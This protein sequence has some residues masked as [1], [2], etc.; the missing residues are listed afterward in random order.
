M[1]HIWYIL[2]KKVEFFMWYA[3]NILIKRAYFWFS[4]NDHLCK[5]LIHPLLQLHW[6]PVC[7]CV[8][9]LFLCDNNSKWFENTA[10]LYRSIRKTHELMWTHLPK[11]HTYTTFR[12]MAWFKWIYVDKNDTY[13]WVSVCTITYSQKNISE[14]FPSGYA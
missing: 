9:L 3:I 1:F 14:N 6:P 13:V 8:Q 11:R 5:H 12:L 10:W 2:R 7:E 4:F